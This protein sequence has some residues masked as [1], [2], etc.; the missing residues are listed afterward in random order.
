MLSLRPSLSDSKTPP[1]RRIR[2]PPTNGATRGLGALRRFAPQCLTPQ[3]S[4]DSASDLR[5]P[6]MLADLDR[7]RSSAHF[8]A[9]LRRVLASGMGLGR[10]A[11]DSVVMFGDRVGF[12]TLEAELTSP[13]GHPLPGYAMLR[14][15]SCACVVVVQ[16]AA[17]PQAEEG[18]LLVRQWRGPAAQLTLEIPAGCMDGQSG[19]LASVKAVEE[20]AEETGV[21]IPLDEL[22]PLG[23]KLSSPGGTDEG[24]WLFGT[25][26]R[27]D[28]S[29]HRGRVMVNP[30][31][32]QE[33]TT[34]AILPKSRCYELDDMKTVAAL[35]LYE[36][37]RT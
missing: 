26:I 24:V 11:F 27:L 17:D 3:R 22:R 21:S 16:D 13:E 31:D 32:P 10:V 14:G 6:L 29:K 7:C 18:V 23:R 2:P 20:L 9:W 33:R 35:A 5:A 15:D 1:T 30:S 4:T 36:R 8:R 25:T 37:A 28:M 19:E 34:T 12:L